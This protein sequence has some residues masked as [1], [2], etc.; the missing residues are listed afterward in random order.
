MKARLYPVLVAINPATL[1]YTRYVQGRIDVRT[2]AQAPLT[3]HQ[4]ALLRL[5]PAW[6]VEGYDDRLL[7]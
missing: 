6:I 1:R 2:Q 4:V 7:A 5:D 3:A